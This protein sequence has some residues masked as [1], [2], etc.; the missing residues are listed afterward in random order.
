MLVDWWRYISATFILSQTKENYIKSIL[1]NQTLMS[2]FFKFSF[3]QNNYV[4]FAPYNQNNIF[5][6]PR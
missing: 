1:S 5:P 6:N 4:P 3:N 2:L